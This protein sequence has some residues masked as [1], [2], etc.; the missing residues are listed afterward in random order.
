MALVETDLQLLASNA[1]VRV[2]GICSLGSCVQ[3]KLQRE[4]GKGDDSDE[5]GIGALAGLIKKMGAI[6]FQQ[7]LRAFHG[8]FEALTGSLIGLLC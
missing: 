1:M 8:A 6:P 3:R 7:N 4:D 5:L 2:T